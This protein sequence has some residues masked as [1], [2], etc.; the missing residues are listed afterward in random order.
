MTI[1]ENLFEKER[2][3]Y[4]FDAD[5]SEAIQSY[6]KSQIQAQVSLGEPDDEAPELKVDDLLTYE[7]KQYRL[8]AYNI[9]H[10]MKAF[11][12]M[13]MTQEPQV[14][15]EEWGTG[16]LGA[17][18][19]FPLSLFDGHYELLSSAKI[20]L[21]RTLVVANPEDAADTTVDAVDVENVTFVASLP[22]MW[23]ELGSQSYQHLYVWKVGEWDTDD[24]QR[25]R[26][27]FPELKFQIFVLNQIFDGQELQEDLAVTYHGPQPVDPA[28]K[29]VAIHE[30][31]DVTIFDAAGRVK[32]KAIFHGTIQDFKAWLNHWHMEASPDLLIQ[33]IDFSDA[34]NAVD[35]HL[36]A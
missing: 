15:L 3:V 21:E 17:V 34:R 20:E 11:F 14:A 23:R 13:A 18:S 32:K 31:I 7:G 2:L 8:V 29:V 6:L 16:R 4:V 22:Q 24:L 30:E 26:Q 25:L 9:E 1:D 33:S 28:T 35:I 27:D 19:Y 5:E 10:P 12:K 36:N